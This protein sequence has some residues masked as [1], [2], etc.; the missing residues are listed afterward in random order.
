MVTQRRLREIFTYEPATGAFRW[1]IN[2]PPRGF[3]GQIAGNDNGRGY[4]K[5]SIGGKRYYAHRM[6]FLY[7]TG[8]VPAEIDHINENKSDNRWVNL[9]EATRSQNNAN[10]S[11]RKGIRSRHGRWYARFGHKHLGTFATKAEALQARRRAE[12]AAGK[13]P[14]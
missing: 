3:A 10:V 13:R 4:I 11:G 2:R 8:S 12:V 5:I 14:Y 9:R 1:R 7:M 6:A